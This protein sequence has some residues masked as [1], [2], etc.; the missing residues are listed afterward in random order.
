MYEHSRSLYVAEEVMPKAGALARALDE[1]GDI[2]YYKA[3]IVYARHAEI[4]RQC[5]EVI[6]CYFGFSRSYD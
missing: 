4:G 5:S 6:I 2:R 1:P 3:G